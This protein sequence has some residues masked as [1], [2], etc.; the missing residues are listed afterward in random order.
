MN[1][2]LW[3]NWATKNLRELL[4]QHENIV[5]HVVDIDK[6]DRIIVVTFIKGKKES[7]NEKIVK[8]GAAWHF[9]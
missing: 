5:A 1:E 4:K 3:H 8:R 9:R 7:L 6:Y 2:R